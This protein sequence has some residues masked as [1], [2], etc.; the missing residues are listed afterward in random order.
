M[1]VRKPMHAI[2]LIRDKKIL[3]HPINPN[4]C[5]QT[6]HPPPL[7]TISYFFYTIYKYII[8][9]LIFTSISLVNK[10]TAASWSIWW[11]IKEKNYFFGLKLMYSRSFSFNEIVSA[12]TTMTVLTLSLWIYSNN[13]FWLFFNMFTKLPRR[14]I[15][16]KKW[17]IQPSK[18]EEM[19]AF[20]VPHY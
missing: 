4:F 20:L 11:S 14:K 3:G 1:L 5:H 6:Y 10:N 17:T 7:P 2:L 18:V 16:L 19:G 12:C 13:M 8:C 9:L 15:Y